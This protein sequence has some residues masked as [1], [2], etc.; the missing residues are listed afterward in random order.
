MLT[1]TLLGQASGLIHVRELTLKVS[2]GCTSCVMSIKFNA[3][4]LLTAVILW[5]R[6]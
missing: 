1:S 6:T 2:M 5:D 3:D 4:A